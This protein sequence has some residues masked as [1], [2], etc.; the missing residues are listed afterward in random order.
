M[1]EKIKKFLEN[2]E[3]L[4]EYEKYSKEELEIMRMY[5]NLELVNV[6]K[7]TDKKITKIRMVKTC[8]DESYNYLDYMLSYRYKVDYSLVSIEDNLERLKLQLSF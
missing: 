4:K 1:E 5:V 7:E 3:I 8:M 2:N 6:K